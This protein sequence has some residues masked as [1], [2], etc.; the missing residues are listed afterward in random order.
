VQNP[1]QIIPFI[2]FLNAVW[3]KYAAARRC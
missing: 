1:L 2:Y 3:L